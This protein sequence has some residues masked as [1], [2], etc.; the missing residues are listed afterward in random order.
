MMHYKKRMY[1]CLAI[2][3]VKWQLFG[4]YQDNPNY[5]T[6]LKTDVAKKWLEYFHFYMSELIMKGE[7]Q[8]GQGLI[9]LSPLKAKDE[10]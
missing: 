3:D 9:G 6:F 8:Q 7:P 10:L 2:L 1:F 5:E 4:I